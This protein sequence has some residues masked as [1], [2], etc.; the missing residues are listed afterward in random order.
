[1]QEDIGFAMEIS[2]ITYVRPYS[3][4]GWAG[5]FSMKMAHVTI[6]QLSET[7]ADNYEPGSLQEVVFIDSL[8]LAGASGSTLTINFDQPFWYNGVDNLL[9][10][11]YYPDGWACA[12]VHNWEAGPARSL[13]NMFLQS[14]SPGTTG[15][16]CSKVPYMILEGELELM[17]MTF[18]GIKVELGQDR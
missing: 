15:E 17:G 4:S 11:I 16:L 8:P 18:A 13:V 1:M 2:S 7:F 3:S 14:G 10:D 12:A 6:D 9:I 5:S